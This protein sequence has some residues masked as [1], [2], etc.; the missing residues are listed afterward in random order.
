MSL[1]P[2]DVLLDTAVTD[3]EP[4]SSPVDYKTAREE[5]ATKALNDNPPSTF[6][7]R[8]STSFPYNVA[9]Q[10]KVVLAGCGGLGNWQWRVL[11]G[12]GFSHLAI[13]DGDVVSV[14]NIG[15][16]HHNI[17]DLGMPKVE[18]VE[19]N[20]YCYNGTRVRAYN[21]KC[22]STFY[23]LADFLGY[24]PDIIIGC[25]DSTEW[26]NSFIDSFCKLSLL[27]NYLFLDFRMSMGD[28]VCYAIPSFAVEVFE[29]YKKL[30][31]FPPEE[32]LQEACTERAI[33]YTGA[34]AAAFTGAF[35]H[36]Y[37][38]KGWVLI[39][40]NEEALKKYCTL[41]KSTLNDGVDF[42]WRTVFSAKDFQFIS[43]TINEGVLN[44]KKISL[45]IFMKKVSIKIKILYFIRIL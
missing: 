8:S 25:T 38:T 12:M 32:G 30:A 36:W 15:P 45:V 40:Q 1:D 41:A 9:S 44:E 27:S 22:P 33:C 17:V 4:P 3:D 21:Q 20:A 34:C 5:V 7:Q 18:A 24:T 26:R 13:F 2:F 11:L 23:E 6:I 35:L 29:K 14:E 10:Q 16:Q 19:H 43:E 31:V 39:R 37:L 42:K 28:F